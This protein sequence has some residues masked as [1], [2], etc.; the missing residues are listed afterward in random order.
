[1]DGSWMDG[2]NQCGHRYRIDWI[3]AQNPVAALISQPTMWNAI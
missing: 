3:D 1:M 2:L